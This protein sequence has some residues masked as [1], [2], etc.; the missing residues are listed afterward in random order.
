MV[1]CELTKVQ[2]LDYVRE[3]PYCTMPELVHDLRPDAGYSEYHATLRNVAK[4]ADKMSRD[5]ILE[6]LPGVRNKV[7]N[8]WA[9]R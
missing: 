8:R 2:L 5:G 4:W 6:K 1:R 3:H 7:P 9:V